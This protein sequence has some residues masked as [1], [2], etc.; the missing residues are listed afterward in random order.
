MTKTESVPRGLRDPRHKRR[1]RDCGD[2]LGLTRLQRDSV[3]SSH[4]QCDACTREACDH[5]SGRH[6]TNGY[7]TTFCGRCGTVLERA[8]TPDFTEI[9]V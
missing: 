6:R 8:T 2:T 3:P 7:G 5:P 1:C 9:Y 4:D